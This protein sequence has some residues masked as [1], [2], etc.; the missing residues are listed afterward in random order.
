MPDSTTDDHPDMTDETWRELGLDDIVPV[1]SSPDY[2]PPERTLAQ[3]TTTFLQDNGTSF[4][5]LACKIVAVIFI[6]L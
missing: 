1:Y 2:S 4:L 6:F 5:A 3:G